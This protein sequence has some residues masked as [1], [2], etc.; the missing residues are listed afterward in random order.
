[1]FSQYQRLRVIA[2]QIRAGMIYGPQFSKSCELLKSRSR[3]YE[4]IC[5]IASLT[6]FWYQLTEIYCSAVEL[7]FL[8]LR[9]VAVAAPSELS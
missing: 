4:A 6:A 7:Q 5:I 9:P 1:M 2:W 8:S 3:C